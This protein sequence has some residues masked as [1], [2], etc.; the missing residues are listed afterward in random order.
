MARAAVRLVGCDA[1]PDNRSS[2]P[3]YSRGVQ[4]AA[5]GVVAFPRHRA[6]ANSS[7]TKKKTKTHYLEE[8]QDD[9]LLVF[10]QHQVVGFEQ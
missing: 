3:V 4:P 7:I 10:A 9:A 2:A 1:L 8:T 5:V 6:T